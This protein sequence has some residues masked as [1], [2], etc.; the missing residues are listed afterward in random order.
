M[1]ALQVVSLTL[2]G[3]GIVSGTC[4]LRFPHETQQ[5]LQKLPRNETM[6]RLLML[7]NVAWSLYLFDQM[8][9]GHWEKLYLFGI[10]LK[11]K[12]VVYVLSPFLYWFIIRYVNHYLGARSLAW[13]LILAAKPITRIC[14]LSDE[15]ARL[16]MTTL[17]YLWVILGILI[18]SVPHWLRDGL[19][20]WQANSTRWIWGCRVKIILGGC[21][22]AL[23]LFA[24]GPH[25]S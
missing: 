18:F 6:G 16:V 1:N 13:F 11:T 22:I 7:I 20:F 15:P 4:S 19:A 24:Y 10:E 8:D 3:F 14:F 21:L 23:G 5:F 17:A 25:N 12:L 2:G 9:L